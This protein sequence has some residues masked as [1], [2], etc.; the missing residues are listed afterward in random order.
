MS[1]SQRQVQ[2]LSEAIPPELSTLVEVCMV[3]RL[4]G[5]EKGIVILVTVRSNMHGKIDPLDDDRRLNLA[6]TRAKEVFWIVGD[7]S[8]LSKGSS[9]AWKELIQDCRER[10]FLRG[11]GEQIKGLPPAA[12]LKIQKDKIAKIVKKRPAT[13]LNRYFEGAIWKVSVTE[14]AKSSLQ[15]LEESLMRQVLSFLGLIAKGAG[16]G[17]PREDWGQKAL[18][19]NKVFRYL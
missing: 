2:I 1:F 3:D 18:E 5:R 4:Q 17:K 6:I 7:T 13:N 8:T 12:S 9:K 11:G 15:K 19:A 14:R 10:G 16:W